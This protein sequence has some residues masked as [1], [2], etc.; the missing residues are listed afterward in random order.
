L[1]LAPP[2]LQVLFNVGDSVSKY[3]GP[4]QKRYSGKIFVPMK[5]IIQELS[6][7]PNVVVYFVD[8]YGTSSYCPECHGELRHVKKTSC[9]RILR[10]MVR[11]RLNRMQRRNRNPKKSQTFFLNS[12]VRKTNGVP[13]G[14]RIIP[15]S[16]TEPIRWP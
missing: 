14:A 3:R 8:E 5:M 9:I 13:S 1:Q 15:R 10:M 2:H 6:K 4:R 12:I 7:L 11:K 16:A